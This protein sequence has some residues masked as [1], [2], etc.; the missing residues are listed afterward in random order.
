MN[1][2][3]NSYRVKKMKKYLILNYIL[4]NIEY[5]EELRKLTSDIEDGVF[6]SLKTN[7]NDMES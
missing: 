6:D 2:F 4:Q 1:T 3:Y 7:E 5:E